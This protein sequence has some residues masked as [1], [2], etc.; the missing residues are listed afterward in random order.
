MSE[1]RVRAKLSCYLSEVLS[2]MLVISSLF[3]DLKN[4]SVPSSD[5]SSS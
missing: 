4:V 5:K 2:V 1:L 3:G